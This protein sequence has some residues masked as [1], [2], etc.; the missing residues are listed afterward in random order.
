MQQ[1]GESDGLKALTAHLTRLNGDESWRPG[2]P[3]EFA[4]RMVLSTHQALTTSLDAPLAAAPRVPAA[5]RS[6]STTTSAAV[7]G[8]A[9]AA[10]S[11]AAVPAYRRQVAPGKGAGR[12]R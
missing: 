5:A 11:E 1:L 2:A 8:A 9:G 12:T 10:P 3:G 4:R 6:R 7:L